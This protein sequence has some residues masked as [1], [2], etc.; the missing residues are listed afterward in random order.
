MAGR[1]AAELP[2]VIRRPSGFKLQLKRLNLSR[3]SVLA[4]LSV[5]LC[6]IYRNENVHDALCCIVEVKVGPKCPLGTRSRCGF[7]SGDTKKLIRDNRWHHG[8]FAFSTTFEDQ[9]PR[10]I[11]FIFVTPRIPIYNRNPE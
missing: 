9:D 6:D 4:A 10:E 5:R 7:C 2:L 3:A 11:L 8:R 1:R